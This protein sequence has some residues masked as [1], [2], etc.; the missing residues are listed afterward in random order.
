M[1]NIIRSED[2]W[3][4]SMRE[5]YTPN[6]GFAARPVDSIM[7][8]RFAVP[9]A[10]CIGA[11][12]SLFL[13]SV[14]DGPGRLD[15]SQPLRAVKI[16]GFFVMFFGTIYAAGAWWTVRT[17]RRLWRRGRTKWERLIY[18]SGVRSFGVFMAFTIILVCTFL[19]WSTDQGRL[20]GP[21]MMF[22]LLSSVFFAFAVCLNLGFFWGRTFAIFAGV[23]SQPT[24]E[25]GD[26]PRV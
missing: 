23:D 24:M 16:A 21:M 5:R 14:I 22:G 13:A 2:S 18:D 7:H 12:S 1:L 15:L 9:F 17:W 10:A 8:M 20:F 11:C 3:F 25:Q 6:P 26:P 4:A 19:G